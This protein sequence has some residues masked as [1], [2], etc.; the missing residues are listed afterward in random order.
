MA[1]CGL[2]EAAADAARRWHG[3]AAGE[4]ACRLSAAC[5]NP[6]VQQVC[7]SCQLG[8]LLLLHCAE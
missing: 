3:R 6:S 4:V 8:A 5:I 1:S 2:G 7:L